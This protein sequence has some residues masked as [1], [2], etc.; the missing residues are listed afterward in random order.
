[1]CELTKYLWSCG[2]F[3]DVECAVCPDPLG[4]FED[5]VDTVVVPKGCRTCRPPPKTN[6]KRQVTKGEKEANSQV[7]ENNLGLGK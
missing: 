4:C 3:K 6:A 1:M 2:H 7:T 5:E